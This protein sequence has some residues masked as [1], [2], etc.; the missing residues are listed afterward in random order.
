LFNPIKGSIPARIDADPGDDPYLIET[1]EDFRTLIISPSIVHGSAAPEA[2]VTSFN[3]AINNLVT[4]KNV[5]QAK[6]MI[7]WAAE[8]VNL[9]TD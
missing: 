7:L 4:T 6:Q 3:D 1:A 9:L 8:D 2:F 5:N